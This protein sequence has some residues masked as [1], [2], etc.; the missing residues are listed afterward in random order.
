[1]SLTAFLSHRL[2]DA[3]KDMDQLLNLEPG[4]KAATNQLNIIKDKQR[5]QDNKDKAVYSKMFAKP[6]KKD[7]KKEE[8]EE[9]KEEVQEKKVEK[10]D[11]DVVELGDDTRVR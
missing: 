4:N 11:D 2:E 10:E 7:D 6:A 5:V 3:K 8:E 1:M 9:K